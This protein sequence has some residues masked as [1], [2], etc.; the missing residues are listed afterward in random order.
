MDLDYANEEALLVAWKMLI[1]VCQLILN[2]F[3]LNSILSEGIFFCWYAN[4]AFYHL[5][6]LIGSLIRR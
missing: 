4:A 1:I 5:I 2:Y 3:Q 6:Y